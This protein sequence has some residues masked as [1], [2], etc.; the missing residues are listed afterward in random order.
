MDREK[1]L[2]GC[3]VTVIVGVVLLYWVIP[4]VQDRMTVPP[5][6]TALPAPQATLQAVSAEATRI[7]QQA[8]QA[9]DDRNIQGTTAAIQIKTNKLRT[10]IA[11]QRSSPVS[12]PSEGK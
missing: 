2:G 9:A 7:A 4:A 12:S 5:T 10:Q 6:A 8:T 3:L 1:V 11:R